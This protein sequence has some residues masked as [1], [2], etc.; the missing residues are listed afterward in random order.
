MDILRFGGTNG[1]VIV[2]DSGINFED[3][4]M[5]IQKRYEQQYITLIDNLKEICQMQGM[6]YYTLA[7]KAGLA[8]S[9][10]YAI[11]DKKTSPNVFTLLALC[12]ALEISIVDLFSDENVVELSEKEKS[13]VRCI[14]NLPQQKKQWLYMALDLLEQSELEMSE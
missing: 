5:S 1:Q 8:M 9:T 3:Y 2:S 7:Q 14:R 4:K 11:M 6:T 13:I 10:V 12:D